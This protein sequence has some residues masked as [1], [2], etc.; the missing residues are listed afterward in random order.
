MA[1]PPKVVFLGRI[2]PPREVL[3]PPLTAIGA[4]LTA[5]SARNE[6]E[7]IAACQDANA[8]I[9]HG[10]ADVTAR[11][12]AALP[13]CRVIAKTGV[14]VDKMDVEAATA[15]GILICN[16]PAGNT[17][18][19]ADQTLGLLLAIT[20]KFVKTHGYVRS[21]RWTAAGDVHA[22]RGPT[23]RLEGRT[24][25]ILGLGRIGTAVARRAEG[26]GLRVIAH[27]PYLSAET[28]A[29]RG[30]TLVERDDL[31]R[32]AHVVTIHAPLTAETRRSVG[33]REFGLMA[34]GSYF[35]NC[36]RGGIVDHA[37][38]LA[39]LQSGHLDGAALDVTDP[40]PL[41]TD[42]PFYALDNVIITAHTAANSEESFLDVCSHAARCVADA[43]AGRLPSSP[44]NPAAFRPAVAAT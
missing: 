37:A 36:A 4:S 22:V 29:E 17:Q 26:F 20:R 25:G 34:P 38:L 13:R 43:L 42:S 30:A 16:A 15:H 27:D 3:E 1:N 2:A 28:A 23:H 24:L 10:R 8:I 5:A 6:D 44:I 7:I 21:G 33:A 9:I 35:L 14:G 18:E 41:P 32:Q 39:A 40:E 31:F 12:L 19:V 11:V